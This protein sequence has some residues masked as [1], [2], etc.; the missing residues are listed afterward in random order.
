[1]AEITEDE[2]FFSYSRY[3]RRKYGEKAYRVSVDAGFSCPHRGS[4]RGNSGCIYCEDSGARAVYLEGRPEKQ[5]ES[6][7]RRGIQ[8]L[9]KRYRADL[10]LLYLQAFTNTYAPVDELRRIYD[11]CLSA[12]TFKEL[13][14]STRPDCIDGGIVE[15][16][17]SYRKPDFDVWVELG[18]QSIHDVT[19]KRIR[20]GHSVR[21]FQEAFSLVKSMGLRS[22]V[23]VMFGLPGETE[24]HMMETID[25]LADI[26]PDGIK[27][28]NLHVPYGTRLLGEYMQGELSVPCSQRHLEYTIR[29]LE[30][31]PR[32]TVIMR[33]TC[34][35][36]RKRLASPK[37][38]WKKPLFYI[39]VRER[40][41]ELNTW[42]GKHYERNRFQQRCSR[43]P[44]KAGALLK[45][46]FGG[47]VDF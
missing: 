27:I 8:F 30:R 40:M 23:H 28:H 15:L 20:R 3:L 29:A 37:N 45:E 39:K 43:T 2:P 1:M 36:P 41:V 6:Q 7:V 18:L 31:L 13:I 35:T 17:A 42:Q 22:A 32:Q 33:L 5:L 19:L 26:K 9:S 11:R 14:V 44:G 10:F 46:P 25:Y 12:G 24:H 4:D 38:F 21:Q 34:D 47:F 16:L